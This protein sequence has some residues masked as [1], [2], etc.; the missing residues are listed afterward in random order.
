MLASLEHV[1]SINHSTAFQVN[2]KLRNVTLLAT[3]VHMILRVL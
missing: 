3:K 1:N 2:S